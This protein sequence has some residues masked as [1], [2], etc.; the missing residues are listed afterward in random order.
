MASFLTGRPLPPPTA[1]Q[2]TLTCNG[3]TRPVVD[4]DFNSDVAA[5]GSGAFLLS[6]AKGLFARA[7]P[8]Q[9]H[10]H[11]QSAV[12]RRRG[13]GRGLCGRLG[14][15]LT[16]GSPMLRDAKTGDWIGTYVGHKGAVWSS[17][18]NRK[19]TRAVTGSADYTAYV[20]MRSESHARS[21]RT[22]LREHRPAVGRVCARRGLCEPQQGLG[23]SER[24]GAAQ[25]HPQAYR[26]CG[27]L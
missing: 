9:A 8:P 14:R 19:G 11:A 6:A 24:R 13:R 4:L 26:S 17:R 25:C 5:D 15:W 20:T 12:D 10:P 27:P 1:R 16:D 18:L 7:R 2:T 21:R 23:C 22:T 3:H